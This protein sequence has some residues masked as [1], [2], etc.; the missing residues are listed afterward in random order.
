MRPFLLVSTRPEEEALSSELQA[1]LK[2][3]GLETQ[4]LE[5]AEFDLV[6][7][8]TIEPQAYCG[9]FVAGSPYG[10]TASGYVSTTQQWVQEELAH[11][12]TQ[13]LQA[14]TP[15]LA[16]G[17]AVGVLAKQLGYELSNELSEVGE[18][19]E[20]ELT[21]EAREDPVFQSLPE[22][23]PAYVNH[24]EGIVKLPDTAV[25]LA[26]SLNTPVQ[27]FRT[28]GNVYGLQFNPELD[29]ELIAQQIAAFYDAG[30]SGIG[31]A[32]S[33][34]MVGRYSQGEHAAARILANFVEVFACS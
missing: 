15:V 3:T 16:T 29:A 17:N 7:L 25:R 12:F 2:A 22:T 14:G 1:Y 31:D 30:D 33:L 6:G 10:S 28:R 5:L 8:P 19:A 20:I 23:F 13:L 27:A 32:E 11:L 26:R 18:I 34:V 21:R 9:V 4:R 24:G